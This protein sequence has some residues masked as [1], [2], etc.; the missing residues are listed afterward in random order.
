MNDEHCNNCLRKK[1]LEEFNEIFFHNHG[2]DPNIIIN[3]LKNLQAN[4][5]YKE[6]NNNL[7]DLDKPYKVQIICQILEELVLKDPIE[8]RAIMLSFLMKRLGIKKLE[9]H[10]I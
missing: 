2:I 5:A 3:N 8:F 9:R 4:N 1:N 7:E 6:I 10:D